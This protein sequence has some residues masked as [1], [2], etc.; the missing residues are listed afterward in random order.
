MEG[1]RVLFID[2]T[3]QYHLLVVNEISQNDN[4]GKMWIDLNGYSY[5]SKDPVREYDVKSYLEKAMINGYVDMT[6][7][8]PFIYDEEDE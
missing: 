6:P 4:D 3:G 7:I 1:I 2:E 5:T 8:G